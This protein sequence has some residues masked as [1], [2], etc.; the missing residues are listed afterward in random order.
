[1]TPDFDLEQTDR[2]LSTTRAVRRRLDLERPVAPEVILECLELAHQSPIG[3]NVEV[4]CW[5]VITEPPLKQAVAEL[6]R[7]QALPYLRARAAA[8][9]DGQRE[10]VGASALFLAENMERVPALVLSCLDAPLDLSGNRE[11][12]PTYGSVMPAVWSFQ[13]ALRSRGLGS[14]WTTLHLDR[15]ADAAELLGIPDG[16]TQIALLPVAYTVGT[17]FKPAAR[18]PVAERTYWNRW[19][20]TT[21]PG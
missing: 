19:G 12:A 14:A 6:Y 16:V 1:M 11:A 8:D 20:V 9:P 7:S 17:D 15:A 2:L 18:V 3:G 5:V 13:L 10:R 21:P 4:R